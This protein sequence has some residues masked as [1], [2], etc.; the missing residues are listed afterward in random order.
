MQTACPRSAVGLFPGPSVRYPGGMA[1]DDLTPKQ[2]LFVDLY[3]A[4]PDLNA[5]AAYRRAYPKCKSEA[6]AAAAASRL[7]RIA[8]VVR[9]IAGRR[10]QAAQSA[11]VN[12]QQVIGEY[13]HLAF[14]DLRELFIS[15]PNGLKMK[16]VK[17]WPENIGRS[18]AGI[19]VRH[20][21]TGLGDDA[22]D[23]EVIELKLWSKTEALKSLAQHLGLLINKHEHS[24]PNGGPIV[25]NVGGIDLAAVVGTKPGISQ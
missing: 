7:L 13:L 8:K 16:P 15:T 12:A 18:I 24:G 11:Q 21:I 5:T 22:E 17:D 20:E 9:E 10:A 6:A 19:K 2:K 23:Y 25:T 3:L 14:N 1:A 4:D